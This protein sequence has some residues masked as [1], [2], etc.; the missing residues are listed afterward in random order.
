MAAEP[1]TFSA[2][3]ADQQEADQNVVVSSSAWPVRDDW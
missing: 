3:E 1:N 2:Q